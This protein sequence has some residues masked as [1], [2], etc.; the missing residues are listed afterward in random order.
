MN[1]YPSIKRESK[2]DRARKRLSLAID[3]LDL[4]TLAT[5]SNSS[6]KT[7]LDE[8][9]ANTGLNKKIKDLETENMQLSEAQV[10][11]AKRLDSAIMRLQKIIKE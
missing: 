1:T 3:S 5:Q 2:V 7:V 10:S 4:I 6:Q 11:I 9:E 8:D